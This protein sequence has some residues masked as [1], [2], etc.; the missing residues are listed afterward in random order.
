LVGV[1]QASQVEPAE[2]KRQEGTDP[3]VADRAEQ[4]AAVEASVAADTEDSMADQELLEGIL[5]AA[6]EE[7]PRDQN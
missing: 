2:E 7:E 4:L 3:A 1:L 6:F 5:A